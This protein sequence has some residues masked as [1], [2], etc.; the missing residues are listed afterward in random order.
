MADNAVIGLHAAAGPGTTHRD[1]AELDHV[2]EVDEWLAGRLVNCRPDLTADL[3]QD[4]DLQVI[5]GQLDHLPLLL[6]R[7]VR[8]AVIAEVRVEAAHG[9]H[10][11]RIG[12]WVGGEDLVVLLDRSVLL[13][14]AGADGG[15]E[16]R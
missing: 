7:L 16:K 1:V 8:E 2:V 15:R 6:D 10:G 14:R 12:I 13:Q 11:V 4:Q 5:V 3:R 9:R